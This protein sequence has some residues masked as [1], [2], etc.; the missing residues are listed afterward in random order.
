MSR[1]EKLLAE[2]RNNP[3]DVR[4]EDALKIAEWLGFSG[5][6]GKG[7]HEARSRP[8]EAVGLNF[9]N[10]GGK[11]PAYQAKQLIAMIDK[12]EGEIGEDDG[13]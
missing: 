8:G 13:E 9:Q 10:R 11:I 12:Y 6:G 3:K 1:R 7:G 2:I 4:Y 5:R